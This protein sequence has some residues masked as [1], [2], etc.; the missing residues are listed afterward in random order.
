MSEC[1]IAEHSSK[2]WWAAGFLGVVRGRGVG[3]LLRCPERVMVALLSGTFSGLL[4][5]QTSDRSEDV[6][7]QANC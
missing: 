1:E 6:M 3:A 5:L 2:T 4:F 7:L